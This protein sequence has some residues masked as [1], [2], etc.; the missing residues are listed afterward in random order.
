M[1]I[2]VFLFSIQRSKK[3]KGFTLVE[4]IVVL[5]IVAILAMVAIPAMTHYID[6]S[7]EKSDVSQL[8]LLNRATQAYRLENREQDPFSERDADSTTL[9]NKLVSEKFLSSPVVPLVSGASY[10]WSLAENQ[11]VYLKE[12]GVYLSLL[13]KDINL[14]DYI[15]EGSW[16]QSTNGVKSSFG[17]LFVSNSKDEYTF[18]SKAT[19]GP[20]SFSN[21]TSGGYG[22]LFETTLNENK[23][24]T[25]Y[26]L[27]LDRGYAAGEIT[28]RPRE[29]GVE[30]PPILRLGNFTNP[31]G[32]QKY[33]SIIPTSKTDPW[34]TEQHEITIEV[35]S[36]SEPGKKNLTVYIDGE[37]V[38]ESFSINSAPSD[39][40][41]FSGVRSFQAETTY[42]EFTIR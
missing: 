29:A 24:D 31:T 3:K 32:I 9:M 28:I 6:L 23:K 38:I 22:I 21:G 7:K 42:E 26:I 25:G 4:I 18:T 13:L 39:G 40:E 5:T 36:S 17:L 15:K 33:S 11:W 14:S 41:K 8:G 20:G 16:T 19:L 2:K 10:Q 12:D 1:E 35:V 37:M 27:Q 34:W 30:K